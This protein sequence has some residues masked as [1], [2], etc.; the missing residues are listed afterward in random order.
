MTRQTGTLT[1]GEAKTYDVLIVGAGFAGLY[2]LH[3]LRQIGLSAVVLEAASGI[4]GTWYNNRYPGLRC[5]IESLLYSY[6][7]DTELQQEWKWSE[8]YAAQPEI[9]RYIHHVADRFDLRRDI[10]LD[11]RVSTAT[12]DA[13]RA[14][15]KLATGDGDM[16]IGRYCVMATGCLSVSNFPFADQIGAFDGEWHHTSAWPHEPV[17]FTGKRV[18]VIGTGSSGIQCIPLIADQA[19]HLTVFQ[20]TA[21]FA[22]PANNAPL[23]PAFEADIKSDY[24]A[25][26]DKN[27]R[28]E[29]FGG[30]DLGWHGEGSKSLIISALSLPAEE[31]REFYESH[32]QRGGA[33]FALATTRHA[34]MVE[35][36]FQ[37]CSLM[38]KQTRLLHSS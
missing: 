34:S 17:D 36:P 8:R 29:I 1:D 32:W 10:Q 37:T 33:H 31:R 16:F 23:D 38:P 5:D 12:F 2:M 24:D 6:S 4:G 28:G 11:T 20:R 25:W 22:I 26:R 14:Q 18:G 19:A 35:A 13:E 3:R 7:F 30:G 21:T 9:L 15:W 27:R